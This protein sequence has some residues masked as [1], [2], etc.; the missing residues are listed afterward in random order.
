MP[1]LVLSDL[2]NL[3][4]ETTAV[5]TL[6]E[7][8]GRIETALENTLSRDGTTPNTMSAPLDMNGKRIINLGAPQSGTDAVRLLDLQDSLELSGTL[9]PALVPNY[10]LSNSGGGLVW[11]QP[12]TLS[13]VGDLRSTNNLS[14]LSNIAT[15]RTNLGLGTA[16]VAA[17]GTSGDALGKLNANLTFSG[18]LSFTGAVTLGG[19]V[20]HQITATPTALTDSS[21]GYRGAPVNSQPNTY[22]FVLGDSGR[23]VVSTSASPVTWTIPPIASVA[24]PLGTVI[25]LANLSASTVTVARGSG[26]TLRIAGSATNANA[27]IAAYGL[28]TLILVGTNTWFISGA[29]VT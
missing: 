15:A 17:V 23:C 22:T 1:K 19:T 5:Q 3:Q 14:D 12:S 13:G 9:L 20:N 7:N 16:A 10:V 18:T 8:F 21:L 11:V 28:A 6:N 27:T 24:Y 2:T 4:S 29:G 25:L 26:V